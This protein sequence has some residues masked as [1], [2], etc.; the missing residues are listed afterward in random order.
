MRN[1]IRLAVRALRRRPGFV[2]TVVLSLALAIGSSAAAFSVV[3]AVRFRALPF[4]DGD[5][6]VLLSEVPVPAT[7]GGRLRG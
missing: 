5:R 4:V 1:D 6:L 2:A 3:D 7:G